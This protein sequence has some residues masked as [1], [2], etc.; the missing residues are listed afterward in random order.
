VL[1]AL[2]FLTGF[3]APAAARAF[4][5]TEK[6]NVSEPTVVNNRAVLSTALASFCLS[7]ID[8]SETPAMSATVS[9]DFGTF[10][11]SK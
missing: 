11:Q 1:S 7:V 8:R 3:G 10:Q 6:S 2:R 4:T 9:M 5:A